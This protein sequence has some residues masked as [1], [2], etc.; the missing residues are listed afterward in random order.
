MLY[1]RVHDP[2]QFCWSLRGIQVDSHGLDYQMATIRRNITYYYKDL[3]L[4]HRTKPRF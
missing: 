1:P 2:G 4:A 3:N